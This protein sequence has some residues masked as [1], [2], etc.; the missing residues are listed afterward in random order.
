MRCVAILLT[1]AAVALFT[2][3]TEISGA[4]CYSDANNKC[5]DC[6]DGTPNCGYGPCNFFGCAC[7]GGC[8]SGDCFTP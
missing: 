3:V 4:C 7:D 5:G 6:T 8:R 2:E 1:F